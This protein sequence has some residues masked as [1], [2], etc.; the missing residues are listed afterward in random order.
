LAKVTVPVDV[1]PFIEEEE[2]VIEHTH[3]AHGLIVSASP[4]TRRASRC[5]DVAGG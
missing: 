1:L 3:D 2:E 5:A 4:I